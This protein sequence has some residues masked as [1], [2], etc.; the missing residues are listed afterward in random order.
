MELIE[1][2]TLELKEKF[3]DSCKHTIVAFLSHGNGTI[4]IGVNDAGKLVK[5]DD[6]NETQKEISNFIADQVSPRC[7]DL[8]KTELE[9]IDGHTVIRID[10]KQGDKLFYIK[11]YGL[12]V[13]GCYIRVGS[14]T[15]EM[16][17]EEIMVKYEANMPKPDIIDLESRK[18]KSFVSSS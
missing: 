4:Y 2:Q 12:S 10:V 11:K 15:R 18:T 5:I 8:V 17:D 1:S 14:T 13:K 16:S 6:I 7:V 3:N 9:D